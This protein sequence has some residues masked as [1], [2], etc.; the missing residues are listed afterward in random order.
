MPK[1]IGY[2]KGSPKAK[3]AAPKSKTKI[4]PKTATKGK[5]SVGMMAKDGSL[6]TG[7]KTILQS[8]RE[9]RGVNKMSNEDIMRAARYI[10]SEGTPKQ[11]KAD[12]VIRNKKTKAR[13][14]KEDMAR[15]P[16]DRKNW[17]YRP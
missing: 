14:Q 6:S 12:K 3:R 7:M 2:P 15:E 9:F 1:G 13:K 16:K 11:K 10:T 17:S 5:K 4:S 8:M